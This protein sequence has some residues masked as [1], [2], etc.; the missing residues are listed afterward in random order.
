MNYSVG[1]DRESDFGKALKA[2]LDRVWGGGNLYLEWST[3]FEA[4]KSY[5]DVFPK[6][7]IKLLIF[8]DWTKE[9]DAMLKDLFQFLKI[10][11]TFHVDHTIQHNQ[12]V[13][14]KNIGVLNFLRGRYIKE[15]IKGILPGR[16]RDWAKRKFFTSEEMD[17]TLNDGL[18]K[19]LM[20]HF[21]EDVRQLEEL[22]SIPFLQKWGFK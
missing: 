11:E 18:R 7:R 21:A 5:F 17:I 14:Y 8:E 4:V 15:T 9:K 13:A 6:E 16:F 19:E 10:D 20:G 22:T 3:Y 1:Y 12:K 2:P